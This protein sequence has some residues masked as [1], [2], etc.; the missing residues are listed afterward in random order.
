MFKIIIIAVVVILV[1]FGLVKLVDKFIPSKFKPFLID[2]EFRQFKVNISAGFDPNRT[3]TYSHSS[4]V[5]LKQL[6]ALLKSENIL[7]RLILFKYHEKPI[8]FEARLTAVSISLKDLIT[9][10]LFYKP[11][12]HHNFLTRLVVVLP[13][14]YKFLTIYLT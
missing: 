14:T 7:F 3:L 5:H 1:T 10:Y 2:N 9:K 13:E 11:T 8:A 12:V 6:N 4:V